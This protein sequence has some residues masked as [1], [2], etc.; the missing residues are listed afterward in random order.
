MQF[1]DRVARSLII[2]A[3]FL[4]NFCT[5]AFVFRPLKY[6]IDFWLFCCFFAS[7]GWT[8]VFHS[9][10]PELPQLGV[11]NS[12]I[13]RKLRLWFSKFVFKFTFFRLQIK[14]RYLDKSMERKLAFLVAK[15]RYSIDRNQK[16]DREKK[17]DLF[18][19]VFNL[20]F[21]SF[22]LR[23]VL[24][25]CF[26]ALPRLQK[27]MF[28]NVKLFNDSRWHVLR[29]NTFS[30]SACEPFGR[31][32]SICSMI[33]LVSVTSENAK[34]VRWLKKFDRISFAFFLALRVRLRFA[35]VDFQCSDD[36][37]FWL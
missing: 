15:N 4:F 2:I 11:L 23:L 1:Y 19:F 21:V 6:S 18:F 36:H 34:L 33:L 25:D 13:Q 17:I 10:V 9:L 31:K 7:H 14:L 20:R 28:S 24:D 8:S 35:F 29:C 16:I 26:P 27:R 30:P 37:N 5:S 32:C 22:F 3:W 12:L